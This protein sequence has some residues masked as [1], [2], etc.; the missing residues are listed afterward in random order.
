MSEIQIVPLSKSD[1]PAASK[2]CAD[3]FLK[4]PFNSAVV[5]GTGDKQ[6]RFMIIGMKMTMKAPGRVFIAKDESTIVGVMRMVQWPD[7][8]KSTPHGLSALPGLIFGGKAF[9]NLLHVRKI[10]KIHD[11]MEPHW[12]LDPLCVL[13]TKQG[14]GI[15]SKLLAHYVEIVEKD[16][17]LAYLE[18]DC[19]ENERLYN[20]FGFMTK[21]TEEI[22]GFKNY[23]MYRNT[24]G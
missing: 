6:L 17:I 4:T 20:R 14:Q 3:A 24:G 9:R 13:S 5:G 8:Q 2:L 10:W 18:T 21:E 7:C 22:F 1:I 19:L 12:H 16:G 23:F 15:G 11:P